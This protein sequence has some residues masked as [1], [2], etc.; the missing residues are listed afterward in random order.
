MGIFCLPR[1]R[2]V[3]L[4]HVNVNYQPPMAQT[5]QWPSI[6]YYHS[7]LLLLMAAVV[8]PRL[9]YFFWSLPL[10]ILPLS[11]SPSRFTF[12]RGA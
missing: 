3:K 12:A 8:F 5:S 1:H 6:F 11:F 7:F 9:L 4:M 2:R 10:L